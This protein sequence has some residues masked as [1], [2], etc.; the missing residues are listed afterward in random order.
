MREQDGTMGWAEFGGTEGW[1][2]GRRGVCVCVR[3][4]DVNVPGGCLK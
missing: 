2:L 4:G 1:M 3:V